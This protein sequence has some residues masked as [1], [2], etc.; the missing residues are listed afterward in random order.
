LREEEL[1]EVLVAHVHLDDDEGIFQTGVHV[2][3]ARDESIQRITPAAPVAT[4]N[5]QHQLV[6]LLGLRDRLVILL[7]GIRLGIVA[8]VRGKAVGRKEQARQKRGPHRFFHWHYGNS[9]AL[10]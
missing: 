7:E 1:V 8:Q 10:H 9:A 4:R 2:V 3:V 6:L 5:H